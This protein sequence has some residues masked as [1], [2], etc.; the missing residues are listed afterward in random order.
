MC[1]RGSFSPQ[2]GVAMTHEYLASLST[3]EQAFWKDFFGMADREI[4]RAE[5]AELNGPYVPSEELQKKYGQA[6]LEFDGRKYCP[7]AQLEQIFDFGQPIT[8]S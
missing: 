3:D 5:E 8:S 6:V 2:I 7:V 4:A 1:G